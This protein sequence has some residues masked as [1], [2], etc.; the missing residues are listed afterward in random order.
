MTTI[1]FIAGFVLFAAGLRAGG[2]VEHRVPG[3]G[4][5]PAEDSPLADLNRRGAPPRPGLIR[6]LLLSR[7][8]R[9]IH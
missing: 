4:P 5:I 8:V 6:L 3:S 9:R 1:L 2:N 7:A